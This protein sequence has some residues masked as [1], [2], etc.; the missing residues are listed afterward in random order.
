MNN[1][2]GPPESLAEVIENPTQCPQCGAIT[3]LDHG[4]CINCLLSAGLEPEGEM[5][6]EAFERILAEDNV[7]DSDGA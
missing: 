6:R 1:A 3:R 2:I 7:A 5:S 4:S